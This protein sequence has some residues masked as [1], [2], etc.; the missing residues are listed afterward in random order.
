MLNYPCDF[1]FDLFVKVILILISN[2]F[3]MSDL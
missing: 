1:D 2:H 3:Q